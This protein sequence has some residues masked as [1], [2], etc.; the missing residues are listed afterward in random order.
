MHDYGDKTLVFE[1]RGLV[2][3]PY[4]DAGVGVI[5]DAADGYLVLNSYEGGAAFTKDGTLIEKFSGGGDH[6]ANF[7]AAVRSRKAEDL[8]ADILEGHLSSAL[9]HLGNISYRLRAPV[10]AHHTR[11][12]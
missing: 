1:V 8:N 11:A 12:R 10:S 9:C 5:F 6:F 3:E 4:R 7:L 2:T